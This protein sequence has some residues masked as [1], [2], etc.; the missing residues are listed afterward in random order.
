MRCGFR[1]FRFENGY[2]RLNGRCIYVRC[3]RTGNCCP[4]GLEPP[5]APDLLRRDLINVKA[6]RFN[7]IRFIAGMAKRYQLDLCDEIR[8]L[9]YE[10]SYAGWCLAD[11][12]KMAERY[13]ES[14]LGMVRRDR[15]HPSVVIWGLLNKTP[16][17]PVFR[18]A[19][20]LLP[21]LRAL[22]DSRMVMLNSGR[23]DGQTGGTAGLEVWRNAEREDPC[24]IHNG[25]DRT[26]KALG[27]TWAPGQLAFHPG[28]YSEY[29][30][31]RWTAPQAGTFELAATFPG[32]AERATTDVHVLHRGRALFDGFINVQGRDNEASFSATLEVREGDTVDCMVGFGNVDLWRAVRHYE[33]LGK[34]DVEDARFYRTNWT[35]SWPTGNGGGW[36]SVWAARR[37]S[38]RPACAR[39]QVRRLGLNAIRS[40]P[41]VVGPS[42]TGAVDQ[43]M[44]GEGLFTTFRELRPGTVDALFEALAPLRWCLFVEPVHVYRGTPVRLEAVLA[45]EDVLLPRDYPVRPQVF[46]PYMV[47]FFERTLTIPDRQAQAEP[48]GLLVDG[49]GLVSL[50]GLWLAPGRCLGT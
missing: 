48:P 9:V 44:T 5:T 6:M 32:I 27:I 7:A 28:C 22:D 46:G 36:P 31:V 17:G 18:H 15:N 47:P 16:D 24:V 35:V 40:N 50:Q 3:S 37:T 2:F 41:H 43:G 10:E 19:V 1:D 49:C 30:M 33:A 13:N 23:W 11:S 8:L 34:E 21:I 14:V 42:L 20:S 25:A 4:V 29:G 39:W 26:I 45:N 12:P 38:S